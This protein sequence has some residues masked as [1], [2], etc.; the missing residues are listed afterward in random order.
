MRAVWKRSKR[1]ERRPRRERRRRPDDVPPRPDRDRFPSPDFRPTLPS[2]LVP[3]PSIARPAQAPHQIR[4][5]T[6]A[7]NSTVIGK[8]G[9]RRLSSAEI[10]AAA[11]STSASS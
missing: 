8:I 4:L 1:E 7:Q 2:R 6:S 9:K 10:F 3:G 11:T 5:C